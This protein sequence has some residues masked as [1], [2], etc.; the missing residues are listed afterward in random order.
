MMILTLAFVLFLCLIFASLAVT[1]MPVPVPM[2]GNAGGRAD[3]RTVHLEPFISPS[4]QVLDIESSEQPMA[5]RP[6]LEIEPLK[7]AA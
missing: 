4:D 7:E 1:F 5:I 3:E 6:Q 2:P